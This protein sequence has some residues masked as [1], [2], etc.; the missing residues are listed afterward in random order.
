MATT[1][2]RNPDNVPGAVT[3][4]YQ[5]QNTVLFA[6]MTGMVNVAINREERTISRGSVFEL[7][8]NI[9][10]VTETEGID[11]SLMHEAINYV[12]AIPDG[13]NVGFHFSAVP[14][15]WSVTK[16]GWYRDDTNE[17][18]LIT[19]IT[20]SDGNIV[21]TNV[22]TNELDVIVPP[23][24]GGVPVL[25]R[26]VRTHESVHLDRGW[27]RYEIVSGG[28]GNGEGGRGGT[29][30][31]GEGGEGG[32]GG[33]AATHNIIEGV[34]FHN[35]GG[36][37]VHVG[38]SGANGFNGVDAA[39]GS[40]AS[41]GGGGGGG[42]GAGEESYIVSGSQ[43]F[44]TDRI[45]PG[46]GG[47]GGGGASGA[48]DPVNDGEN[49]SEGKTGTFVPGGGGGEG[50]AATHT[51]GAGGRGAGSILEKLFN[52]FNDNRYVFFNESEG[53]GGGAG[54]ANTTGAGQSGEDGVRNDAG[55]GGAGGG[56]GSGAGTG[57]AGARGGHG[58]AA[59][60][61]MRPFGSLAA[62]YVQIWR[63]S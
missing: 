33:V 7:N 42:A 52:A 37:I 27:H 57:G 26:N 47:G 32:G 13:E 9:V 53:V 50:V 15:G 4:G 19:A 45:G 3:T 35:G 30:T 22:L 63:L 14:P 23:N 8:G 38:G 17:R 41:S 11:G 25:E 24:A 10:R 29:R 12:Y 34:F 60:G 55:F 16:G 18:A 1:I 2:I 5:A 20:D 59:P 44:S 56:G 49:G 6:S 62:G 51:G 61:W 43:K 40:N 54:G 36:L 28:T 21:G 39:N 31:F 48:A 58:G 46:G